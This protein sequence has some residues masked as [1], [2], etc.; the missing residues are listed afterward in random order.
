MGTKTNLQWRASFRSHAAPLLTVH[1]P[2]ARQQ[3]HML[4][5]RH[6]DH[7]DCAQEQ[8]R[9]EH[10]VRTWVALCTRGVLS[11]EGLKCWCDLCELRLVLNGPVTVPVVKPEGRVGWPH[12]KLPPT[13]VVARR[14][15][16]AKWGWCF[17]LC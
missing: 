15:R 17:S 2:L 13:A 12:T 6:R 14:P 5:P 16:K 4:A 9:P 11:S 7:M 10:V 8:S 1:P 3:P